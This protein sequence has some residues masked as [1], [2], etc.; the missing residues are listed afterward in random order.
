MVDDSPLEHLIM[1]KMLESQAQFQDTVHSLDGRVIIDFL[2]ENFAVPENLPDLILLDLNMPD[3]SG[4]DFLA[5]FAFLAP[6]I[7]K[8]VCIYILS[9]SVDPADKVRALAYPF[10]KDFFSKPLRREQ[11]EA[12]YLH[13]RNTDRLAG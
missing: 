10:V 9:S 4:W 6:F 7:T 13:H 1:Q 12:L 2:R 8:P 5:Q 3:F 11:L